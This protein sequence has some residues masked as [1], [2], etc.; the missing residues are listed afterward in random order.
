MGVTTK[1]FAAIILLGELSLKLLNKKT[2][3]KSIY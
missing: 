3:N 1:A 2:V